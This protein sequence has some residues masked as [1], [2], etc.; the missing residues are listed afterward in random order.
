MTLVQK[1]N[2]DWWRVVKDDGNEGFVPANY[3]NEIE[4]RVVHVEVQTPVTA[5]KRSKVDSEGE[6]ENPIL[7]R[8]KHINSTYRRLNKLAQA[9]LGSN[10]YCKTG[11]RPVP[12]QGSQRSGKSGKIE[13]F[14]KLRENVPP[15]PKSW[16]PNFFSLLLK[17]FSFS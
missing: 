15:P 1:T 9:S 17:K 11:C 7:E 12:T 14:L 6:K 8:Q 13:N 16:E 5:T 3:V 2:K 10:N 4:G